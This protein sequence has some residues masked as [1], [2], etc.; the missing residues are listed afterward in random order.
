LR[1]NDSSV[2]SGNVDPMCCRLGVVVCYVNK[3]KKGLLLSVISFFLLNDL[4]IATK[5]AK[6]N[7]DSS[8]T[9]HAIYGKYNSK[10]QRTSELLMAVSKVGWFISS[11]VGGIIFWQT[12]NS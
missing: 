11:V 7:T 9:H 8:R 4:L 3:Y 5:T 1:F 12:G 6:S 10:E 2:S